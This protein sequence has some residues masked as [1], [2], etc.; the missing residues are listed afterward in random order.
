[1]SWPIFSPSFALVV[2]RFHLTALNGGKLV[3]IWK[4]PTRSAVTIS[5]FLRELMPLGSSIA[6]RIVVRSFRES[7]ACIVQ[8]RALPAA[9]NITAASF[10][11][12]FRLRLSNR[13]H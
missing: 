12:R 13:D 9:A 3:S 10:D 11:P 8:S 1:M 6:A 7:V 2:G 5:R 4:S